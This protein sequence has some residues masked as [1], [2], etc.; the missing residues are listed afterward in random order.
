MNK[1]IL[2]TIES[3]LLFFVCGAAPTKSMLAATKTELLEEHGIVPIEYLEST[4]NQ[5]ILLPAAL[6]ISGIDIDL[7]PRID[8]YTATSGFVGTWNDGSRGCTINYYTHLGRGVIIRSYNNY[9]YSHIITSDS[10][11]FNVVVSLRDVYIN[12]EYFELGER[13]GGFASYPFALFGCYN[14]KHNIVNCKPCR[15]GHCALYSGSNLIPIYDFYP[16]RIGKMGYML[17]VISGELFGNDGEGNFIL[18]PDVE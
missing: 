9:I 2:L 17:D 1:K 18:G 15:I 6:D 12:G 7:L 3:V 13:W 11:F 8:T 14:T 16:V 4:D 5:Y 10:D